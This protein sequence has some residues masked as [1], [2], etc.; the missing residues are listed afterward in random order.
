MK[1]VF[2]LAL[3][4]LLATTAGAVELRPIEVRRGTEGL[5]PA[6]LSIANTAG[7]PVVCVGELAHWY[8]AELAAIATGATAT[9]D[10]WFDPETGTVSALNEARENMPVESL[11]CGIAGEAYETRATVALAREAG[12][13]AKP[14]TLTCTMG[15]TRLTCE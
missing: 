5:E 4:P 6:P 9:I 7:V 12:A 15:D 10:L 3:L 8:S 1:V 14:R 13:T 2:A 11:W